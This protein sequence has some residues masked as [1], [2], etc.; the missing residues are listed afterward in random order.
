MVT[1]RAP[2]RACDSS[3]RSRVTHDHACLLPLADS[4]ASDYHVSTG[5]TWEMPRPY[6]YFH[7]PSAWNPGSF[8][9]TSRKSAAPRVELAV[10][11]DLAKPSRPLDRVFSNSVIIERHRAVVSVYSN[12]T[13]RPP[14]SPISFNL[15]V[16][17]TTRDLN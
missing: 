3:R 4:F 9:E 5:K 17:W 16:R 13:V 15:P 2:T 8:R 6:L 11:T 10:K 1:R 7:V 12:I 14:R